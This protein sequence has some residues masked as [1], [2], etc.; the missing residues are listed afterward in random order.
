[1]S[2]T[3]N[4]RNS[5]AIKAIT[6]PDYDDT[7]HHL[8]MVRDCVEGE[9][10][11]KDKGYLYLPHPSQIDSSSNEQLIRYREFK[12][13]AEFDSFTDDTRREMIGKMRVSDSNIE[14]PQSLEYLEY[15]SDGDGVPLR[16]AIELAINNVLQVKWHVLVADVQNAPETLEGLSRADVEGLGT[17]TTIKQYSRENVVNWNFSRINGVMQLSYI[18]LLELS[19]DFDASTGQRK[20]IESYLILALDDEG[21]YYQQ[22]ERYTGESKETLAETYP[23][24]D[25]NP[26]KWLP[27]VIF[28]DE[29]LQAG[30]LP[31]Q[32]G[33]LSSIASASL[34]RYRV[35]AHYKET[36]RNM[37]P[38][39]MNKGWQE[40]DAD[41]FKQNNGGRSYIATG[42]G[43]VNNLPNNVEPSVL[44]CATEMTDFHWYF[45][46]NE[47][48]IRN[49]GGSANTQGV[50]MTATEADINAS[51][52]NAL[53]QTVADN[54]ERAFKNIVLY[55]GMFE[56][57]YSAGDIES[58]VEDILIELPRDFATPKL[59]VEE[60]RVLLDGRLQGAFT[61]EQVLEKLSSGGWFKDDV[62]ALIASLEE[63]PPTNTVQSTNNDQ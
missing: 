4:A 30:C 41:I 2:T 26:L 1:M 52:Q 28:S 12:A 35:S 17:R 58:N 21:N 19:E 16:G 38:T 29:E 63:S 25:G 32:A 11:V 50:T 51:K 55:C 54:A 59:T 5:K 43:A 20:P 18:K 13:G 53:L 7:I 44:S 22:V 48:K 56:G 62:Q 42:A 14:L 27:V 36:Q 24:I 9:K 49:L 61:T 23:R 40:G 60:V 3:I 34:D 37:A 6:H 15:N 57:L 45:E 47:K 10:A 46:Q 31:K 8:T 33:Y 39:I